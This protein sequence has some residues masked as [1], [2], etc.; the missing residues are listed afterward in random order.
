MWIEKQNTQNKVLLGVAL[1]FLVY[2]MTIISKFNRQLA[3]KYLLGW[4]IVVI[5][6]NAIVNWLVNN[7]H[8][9][10]AWIVVLSPLVLIPNIVNTVCTVC[11]V[12]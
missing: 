10:I 3:L 1:T 9:S 11:K 5:V 6:L 4:L 8:K 12:M 7:G 2:Q